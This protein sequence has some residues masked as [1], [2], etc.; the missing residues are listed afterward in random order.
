MTA[1]ALVRA[2]ASVGG[3]LLAISFFVPW[4]FHNSPCGR[5]AWALEG[6]ALAKGLDDVLTSI[7]LA[8][9]M[10]LRCAA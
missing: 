4:C 8:L 7:G 2:V 3:G 10:G 1:L 5:F 9:A 6:V